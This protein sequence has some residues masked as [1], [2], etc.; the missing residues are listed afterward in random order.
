MFELTEEEKQVRVEIDALTAQAEGKIQETFRLPVGAE[1]TRKDLK[2]EAETLAKR[3]EELTKTP[4]G[5]TSLL[6]A[7]LAEAV[8]E[9]LGDFDL[10][11][12]LTAAES[13]VGVLDSDEVTRSMSL[14]RDLMARTYDAGCDEKLQ[15][16]RAHMTCARFNALTGV[17]FTKEQALQILCAESTRPYPNI[18]YGGK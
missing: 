6:K 18:N 9:K 4:A 2:E 10:G 12:I 1:Q 15:A 3:A 7:V 14:I 5:I 13:L 8:K 16:A 11:D 17:G